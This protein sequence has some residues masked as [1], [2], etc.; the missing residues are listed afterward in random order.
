MFNI[1]ESHYQT[2]VGDLVEDGAHGLDPGYPGSLGNSGEA[3][4]KRQFI[5]WDQFKIDS[6]RIQL[7]V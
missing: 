1:P 4:M 2:S 5:P 3:V 6:V 7:V